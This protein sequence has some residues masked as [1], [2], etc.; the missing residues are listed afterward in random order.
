MLDDIGRW[1]QNANRKEDKVRVVR[2]MF[3]EEK[4]D[5]KDVGNGGECKKEKRRKLFRQKTNKLDNQVANLIN[6]YFHLLMP[7]HVI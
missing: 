3:L 1:R 6:I 2:E 4:R 5:H 7:S